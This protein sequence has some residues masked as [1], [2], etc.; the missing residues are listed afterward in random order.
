MPDDPARIADTKSWLARA[1][2]D[3][4]AAERLLKPPALFSAAVFH[5]QQAAEKTL[6]G[7]LAWHD[8]PFRKTHNLEETGQAC[9]AINA[10]LRVTID[11]AIPLTEYAWKFRYPGAVEEPT[12]E[13]AQDAF[14]AAGDVYTAIIALIPV[15]AKP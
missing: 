5:C 14:A 15:E 11:R 8:I 6:K 4:A 12:R 9:I 13:E 10:N 7:F 2:D 1:S 3:I